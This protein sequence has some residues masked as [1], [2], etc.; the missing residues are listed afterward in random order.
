MLNYL[1]LWW[2]KAVIVAAALAAAAA[3]GAA[4]NGWRLQAGFAEEKAEKVER[5]HELELDIERQNSAVALL[6]QAK[7][8]AD[9]FRTRAERDAAAARNAS[10]KRDE[11]VSALKGTCSDNLKDLWSRP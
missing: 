6:G 9:E 5:I 1:G 2:V 7:A 11:W 10:V 4:V 8:T 3:C